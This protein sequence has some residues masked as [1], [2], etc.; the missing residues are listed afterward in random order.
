MLQSLLSHTVQEISVADAAQLKNAAFIDAREL[1]EYNVSHLKNAWWSGYDDFNAARLNGVSKEL[2]LIV[3]CSVGYRS[4]K[5][6]EKLIAAGYKNTHNLYGGIFE[7]KN[8]GH[9]VYDTNGN[10]T[11]KVHAYSK[12]WGSWLTKGIRVYD[13]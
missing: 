9:P 5:I 11:E 1:N 3:Y 13:N 12:S 6:A 8:Q 2:T 4:E 7:W 10:E